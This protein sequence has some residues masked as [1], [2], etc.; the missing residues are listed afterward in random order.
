MSVCGVFRKL[1]FTDS[2]LKLR[3]AQKVLRNIVFEKAKSSTEWSMYVEPEVRGR[4]VSVIS[5]LGFLRNF[6]GLNTLHM[7]RV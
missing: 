5:G 4:S 3:I 2:V 1:E 6:S 7:D